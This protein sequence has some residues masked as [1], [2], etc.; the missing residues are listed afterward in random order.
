MLRSKPSS[1]RE[2]ENPVDEKNLEA[3]TSL[4]QTYLE[5]G[6]SPDD[7]HFLANFSDEKR[8]KCVRKVSTPIA[9]I[10][11]PYLT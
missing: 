4:E 6:L 7:A 11:C 10:F 3:A 8:K 5:A 9:M 2:L 1:V